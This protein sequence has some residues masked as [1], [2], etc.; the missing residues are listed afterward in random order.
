VGVRLLRGGGFV[1]AGHGVIRRRETRA[2]VERKS[3]GE[4]VRAGRDVI[5]TRFVSDHSLIN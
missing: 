4:A 5:G 3:N 2:I 1:S